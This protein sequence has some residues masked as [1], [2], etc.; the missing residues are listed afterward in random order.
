MKRLKKETQEH[1]CQQQQTYF[2]RVIADSTPF[3]STKL[4]PD[5]P[6]TSVG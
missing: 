4:K 6:V 3:S 2:Y 1:F 5:L